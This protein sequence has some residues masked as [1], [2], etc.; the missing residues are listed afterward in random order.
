MYCESS[1]MQLCQIVICCW[2]TCWYV[3]ACAE[4]H[5]LC[6]LGCARFLRPATKLVP[7]LLYSRLWK[8]LKLRVSAGNSGCYI[9]DDTH[10]PWDGMPKLHALATAQLLG[11]TTQ[12]YY[13]EV[14]SRSCTLIGSLIRHCETPQR[15]QPVPSWDSGVPCELKDQY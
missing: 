15:A 6:R 9:V 1:N 13:W 8:L 2:C 11:V 4:P 5:C 12:T 7:L 14:F 3:F 10:C